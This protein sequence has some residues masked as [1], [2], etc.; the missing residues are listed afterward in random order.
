MHATETQVTLRL[1]ELAR[2]RLAAQAAS[3]GKDL[4]AA[5]SDLIEHAV[6]RPTLEEILA[7]V[8]QQVADSGMSEDQLDDFLREELNAHRAEKKAKS[9]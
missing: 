5:A 2:S 8:H 3:T 4:S 1:S 7:P 6:T 9:A